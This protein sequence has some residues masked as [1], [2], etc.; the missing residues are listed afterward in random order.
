L[1]GK[2][3]MYNQQKP[4]IIY[5]ESLK[6]TNSKIRELHQTERLPEFSVVFTSSQTAGRGQMGN[7]WESED[8]MNLTFSMLL[9]PDFIEI[10]QQ[11]I[12]NYIITVAI[13]DVLKKHIPEIKIKWAN[14]IYAGNKK[15]A[16]ILIENSI[17]GAS[18]DYSI[19]GIG[20]NVNQTVFV[21]DAPNP[22]S[23]K[24]ISGQ[25]YELEPL[26][27][28]IM[29]AIIN[30]YIQYAETGVEKIKNE[31]NL[32]L[33]R[34]KGFFPYRDKDGDFSARIEKIDESGHLM[35]V[36][37]NGLQRKYAFKE[38]VFV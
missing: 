4:K 31:Y 17:L 7:H 9:Y 6:S 20:L 27:K 23:M 37:T 38:V 22:V 35:L 21:S 2:N 25:S 34:S 29:N 18:I 26:L 30:R 8:N 13:R 28:D 10:Q 19:V 5:F 14:D 11:F 12:L 16:G 3:I 15:L 32:N 36:D 1:N 33:Y 24:M